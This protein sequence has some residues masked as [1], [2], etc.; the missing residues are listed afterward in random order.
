MFQPFL[1]RILSGILLLS[2][3]FC[4]V[5]PSVRMGLSR[6]PLYNARK[7]GRAAESQL[8]LSRQAVSFVHA[9]IRKNR[10]QLHKIRERS[11]F[12]FKAMDRVFRAYRLPADLKYLAVIESELKPSAVSRVGAT[13][14]WQ[15]MPATAKL[16]GLK[17]SGP[18]DERRQ[19]AKSTRAAAIYLRDLYHE[20]GD[21][22]LVMAAYNCGPGPVYTAMAKSGSQ[23]FWQLQRFLPMESQLHVKK[24]IATQYYFEGR[25]SVCTLTRSELV[26]YSLARGRSTAGIGLPHRPKARPARH[27]AQAPDQFVAF[28][29]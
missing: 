9:Y 8:R 22:L 12:P 6:S 7:E 11:E 3:M 18:Q 20:F 5:I 15:F 14:P 23:N 16:L 2:L 10:E 28:A 1:H 19:Y 25:G 17:I 24:F 13:G 26:R 29:Q 4:P 21:W 27:K